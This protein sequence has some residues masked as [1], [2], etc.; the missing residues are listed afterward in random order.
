MRTVLTI[1]GV[2][3]LVWFSTNVFAGSSISG[4]K[5]GV[6]IQGYDP[7]AYFTQKTAVR[8]SAPHS[9]EWAGTA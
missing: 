8:G 1:L 9:Y 2:G 6:A 4:A 3:L 5:D 7:V